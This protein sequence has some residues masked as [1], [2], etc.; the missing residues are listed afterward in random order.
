MQTL[1]LKTSPLIQKNS[2]GAANK[3]ESNVDNLASDAEKTPFHMELAKQV[4]AKKQPS[5]PEQARPVSAPNAAASTAPASS[6]SAVE[7]PQDVQTKVLPVKGKQDI[8]L[9]KADMEQT[10]DQLANAVETPPLAPSDVRV[11]SDAANPIADAKPLPESKEHQYQK[12]QKE[13][14]DLKKLKDQK[15]IR[16][17]DVVINPD[18]NALAL[19]APNLLVPSQVIPR[20]T[21][22]VANPQSTAALSEGEVSLPLTSSLPGV[23]QKQQGL[24]AMLGNALSQAKSTNPVETEVVDSAI[25]KVTDGKVPDKTSWIDNVLENASPKTMRDDVVMSKVMLNT[26]TD[27]ASKETPVAPSA[28]IQPQVAQVNNALAAQQLG[29]SNV[30]NAYPGKS[31][32]DQAISQKIVWMVG[33]GEQTASLTLNPPDLGPLKVVIHVHNDQA[34]TTFISDNHEVRQAL[35]NGF[36]NLRDKMSES[37]IQLGQTNVSTSSQSQQS[38]QQA[39]QNRSLAQA[40]GSA[41]GTQVPVTTSARTIVRVANGLVD[42]F[43]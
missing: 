29:S 11:D 14:K 15:E 27:V 12:D 19:A 3:N 10:I 2:A 38:F 42:T 36:S 31:G 13:L 17:E 39:A 40:Q 7:Q 20:N 16:A 8:V 37:G 43:A 34:D 35:E 24:D 22:P 30:I 25:G 4:Q 23:A 6:Q 32:W 41:N 28:A 21:V 18:S 33:T 1:S 9:I 26:A 5:Q